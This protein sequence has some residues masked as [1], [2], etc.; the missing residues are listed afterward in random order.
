MGS[1]RRELGA[2][3]VN[4]NVEAANLSLQVSQSVQSKAKTGPTHKS[5]FLLLDTSSVYLLPHP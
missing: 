1:H 5:E 2:Y 3:S 4:D